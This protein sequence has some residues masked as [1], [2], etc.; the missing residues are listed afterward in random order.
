MIPTPSST[1]CTAWQTPALIAPLPGAQL[2][3][4]LI[5][6]VQQVVGLIAEVGW[7]WFLL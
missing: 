5:Y 2:G 4:V 3:L 7:W 1:S 6:R